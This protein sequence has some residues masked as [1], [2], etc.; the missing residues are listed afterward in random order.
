MLVVQYFFLLIQFHFE[1]FVNSINQLYWFQNHLLFYVVIAL[2]DS[3][4]TRKEASCVLTEELCHH[5]ITVGDIIDQ[6]VTENRK[7]E[8]KARFLAYNRKIGL[9]GIIR[10]YE[11]GCLNLYEMSEFLDTTE[12]FLREAL[13]NYK[14]KY[15]EYVR[16]DNYVVS[17]EPT[18]GV[19]KFI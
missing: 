18:L 8:N 19:L 1:S 4:Q 2:S 16:I 17:F 12:E 14:S 13:E 11:V 6:N 3:I 7:Q 5:Y 10:A 9:T 15:G